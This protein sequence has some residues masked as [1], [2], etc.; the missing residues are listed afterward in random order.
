MG[1]LSI[2]SKSKDKSGANVFYTETNRRIEEKINQK[3]TRS[4]AA[5]ALKIQNFLN[6]VKQESLK[7][8]GPSAGPATILG[9]ELE[10]EYLDGLFDYSQI[11][12]KKTTEMGEAF[13]ADLIKLFSIFF[14]QN[15]AKQTGRYL[16]QGSRFSGGETLANA[17]DSSLNINAE[18]RKK[19]NSDN[20]L[21]EIIQGR[22][23]QIKTDVHIGEIQGHV[24]LSPEA[25]EVYNL[26]R[27]TNI[28]AKNYQ[29]LGNNSITVN[30]GKGA[31]GRIYSNILSYLYN[32]DSQVDVKR[33]YFRLVHWALARS[34]KKFSYCNENGQWE[35]YEPFGLSSGDK[36]LKKV[37]FN[38][39]VA[40]EIM[41]M[42]QTP[43]YTSG[44]GN[45]Q[46]VASLAIVNYLIVNERGGQGRIMVF[47]A[48]EILKEL[49]RSGGQGNI[50]YSKSGHL[51]IHTS[52]EEGVDENPR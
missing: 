25:K 19:F 45:I 32:T 1:A 30:V 9:Q 8:V 40:Y 12:S 14:S 2:W 31:S 26:L 29:E 6:A 42:G 36:A 38:L 37:R 50:S 13:E 22:D 3:L 24:D 7:E 10:R 27:G 28:S 48:S 34:R 23:V 16:T 51:T 52:G 20:Q 39:R 15:V 47:S 46:T 21:K 44:K 41:G 5:T 17:A 43:Y 18:L 11:D 4:N 35:S 33:A 49:I